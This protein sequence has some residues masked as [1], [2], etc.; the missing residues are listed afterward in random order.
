MKKKRK[1]AIE[2]LRA[3]EEH[4]RRLYSG[5]TRPGEASSGD[6]CPLCK[7]YYDASA[8]DDDT[9]NGC[10]V[11]K[12][13]GRNICFGTPWLLAHQAFED[14]YNGCGITQDGEDQILREVE[15]LEHLA[16][17]LEL[18]GRP[19]P[20][21]GEEKKFARYRELAPAMEIYRKIKTVRA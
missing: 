1:I 10:P 18:R 12:F 11:K 9:C 6:H 5:D 21:P 2:L 19:E 15:F 16:L 20:E 7:V 17:D 3:S 13:T 8:S 4:W 14:R